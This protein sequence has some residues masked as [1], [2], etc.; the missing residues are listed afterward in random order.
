MVGGSNLRDRA[1]DMIRYLETLKIPEGMHQGQPFILRPWQREIINQVYGPVD[2]TG[3]RLCRMAVYSICKKNGKTPFVAGICLAHLHGPE[4]KRNEQIYSAA[5]DRDQAALVYRYMRQM[6]EM[7]TE[8]SD[9]INIKA[10]VK[11]MECRETG[12]RF[13]ALSSEVKGKHGLGPAVIVFDEL[14]QFGA[15]REFYDTLMQGRG[16]HDEPLAWIISTQ[17]PDDKAVLSELIDYGMKVNA[18]EIKDPTFRCFLWTAPMDADPHDEAV[19]R[20]CNPALGDFL[21]IED[22]REASRTAKNMPSAEAGFRNLRLNQRVDASA[23]FITPTI[24]KACGGEAD[25]GVFEDRECHGGLD[26]SGKNDL[27]ALVFTAEDD[28]GVHH[29]LCYFW[30]PA[31]G[32]R[33]KEKRDRAPYCL[34]RDQGFLEAKP[35]KI[36][37]YGWIARK[38]AKLQG[39]LRI[40]WIRFDRWRIADLQ[41]EL[42]DAG[43]DCWIDGIDWSQ[44]DKAIMPDGLRLIPHGQG[45]KDMNPAVENLE[46]LLIE[47]RLR[48]GNNP[49]L[50]YCASNVRIQADPAG[51]RKFD[52]LKSTGRIDGM[53]SL[54]MA[55]SP[56]AEVDDPASIYET[57]GVIML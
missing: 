20:A 2:A 35:G 23:H 48:H 8:L 57:R 16:A 30:T 50:T 29:V 44:G 49:V 40:S 31:D 54:A 36:I 12:G 46:D 26:L 24:W 51:N 38:L 52:K 3:K 7:D 25:L 5:F 47:K 18:G 11:E 22:M 55:L 15:D 32:L 21:N 9:E 28:D 4:A 39:I 10:S 17:S 13:K 42:I 6:V 43:V 53:V 37:D 33:E 34:W 41:R 45:F 19:W 1:A 27:T 14:A 56:S